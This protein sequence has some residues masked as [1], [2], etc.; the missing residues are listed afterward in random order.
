MVTFCDIIQMC[1]VVMCVIMWY[2]VILCGIVSYCK[3]SC[4]TAW[5]LWYCVVSACAKKSEKQITH[6]S[7]I[8]HICGMAF[9][10]YPD[11]QANYV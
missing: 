9:Y 10:R 11:R 2:S 7:T 1:C 4:H 6:Q 8:A 3:V 5:Y